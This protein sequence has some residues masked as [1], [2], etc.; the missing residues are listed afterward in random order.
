MKFYHLE[1]KEDF[2]D[3]THKHNIARTSKWEEYKENTAIRVGEFV[4]D[5]MSIND[6]KSWY[7]KCE[8]VKYKRDTSTECETI[9]TIRYV[10]GSKGFQDFCAGNIINHVSRYKDKNS[11]ED[12]QEARKYIELL[13]NELMKEEC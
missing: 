8:I 12:I 3:F 13:E 11:L 2:D 4:Y 7:P 9:E 10:L 1:T 6:A 5:I